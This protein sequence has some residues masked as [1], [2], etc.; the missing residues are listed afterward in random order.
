MRKIGIYYAYWEDSWKADFFPYIAKVK[1]LGFN[2]LEIQSAAVLKLSQNKRDALKK[3]ADAHNII[4]SYG[5]GLTADYD[6]SSLDNAIRKNGIIFMKD[7]IKAVS[8]IEGSMISGTVHSY[9]PAVFPEGLTDKRPVWDASIK[10]MREL[11][12]TAEDYNV[13]LNVEVINRFEQF[14]LNTSE[15]AVQYVKEINHPNCRILLDTFHMN[16]EEDSIEHAIIKAGSYLSALHLGE[17][18]RKPPGC[19][20]IPWKEIKNA[21]DKIEFDGPLI[22]EPFVKPGGQVG[23]DIGVWRDMM[24]GA[25]LDKEAAIAAMFVKNTLC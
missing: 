10:S 13:I 7:M 18:N 2:Q 22:M 25:D 21:L 8:S 14:L 9:W 19:G 12:K 1:N 16:I 20:R 15:E 4:L 3:E 5:I 11:V 6:V 23:R 24:P 17:T